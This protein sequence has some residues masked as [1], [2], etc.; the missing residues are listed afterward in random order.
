MQ[1]YQRLYDYIYEYW[2]EIY[3]IYAR[4][5][6]AYLVTYYNI[7]TPA[8]VWDNE[9]LMGGSYEKIGSLS[10]MR[11]NRYLTLPVFFISETETTYVAEEIGYT[12]SEKMTEFVIPSDYGIIPYPDDIIKLD[13]RY[14]VNNLSNDRF[15]LYTITGVKK[16]SPADKT[17]YQLHCKVQSSRTTT[18]VDAQLDQTFV[19]FDYDKKIHT[20]QDSVILT[21]MLNKN[22]T[23][24]NM[25][26]TEFDENSG[27]YYI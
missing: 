22:D 8:T 12:T 13:Q 5:A 7:S 16:Q 20:V 14:L 1:N 9:K 2:H 3:D 10:G 11:W 24:S 19:F 6:I 23:I 26:R 18:E 4:H 27:F 25:L 21:R 17:Y 15:S